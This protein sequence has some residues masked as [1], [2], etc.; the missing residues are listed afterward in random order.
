QTAINVLHQGHHPLKIPSPMNN[1]DIF[2][3]SDFGVK[4]T[5][6]LLPGTGKQRIGKCRSLQTAPRL[7]FSASKRQT[8]INRSTIRSA[9]ISESLA[10]SDQMQRKSIVAAVEKLAEFMAPETLVYVAHGLRA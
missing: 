10:I 2:T 1:P 9:L 7:G 8:S 5:T 6:Y 4:K 3:P